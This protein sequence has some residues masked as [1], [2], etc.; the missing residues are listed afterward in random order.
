LWIPALKNIVLR[1]GI[2]IRTGAFKDNK[3]AESY[4]E[5]FVIYCRM[6]GI[7]QG[8]E[9]NITIGTWNR[10]TGFAVDIENTVY[11]SNIAQSV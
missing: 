5:G 10:G 6:S 9:K 7:K 11:G 4:I 8:S 2:F 1:P 3:S